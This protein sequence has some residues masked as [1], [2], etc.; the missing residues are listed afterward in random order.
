VVLG[1][2]DSGQGIP[3][4]VRDRIFEPFFTTKD[5][6]KGTGLGLATVL[7]IVEKCGGGVWLHSE[8]NK[9]TTFKI[10]FPSTDDPP[11]VPLDGPSSPILHRGGTILLV[12]DEAQLRAMLTT[13]LEQA[14]YQVLVASGPVEALGLA[15]GHSEVIDLLLTD[16]V[17]PQ[18]TGPALAAELH[19]RDP[20]L[21]VLFM[22]GFTDDAALRS[23]LLDGHIN[24]LPKPL[25]ASVLLRKIGKLLAG[26]GSLVA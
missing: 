20:G 10:Y 18:M 4:D 26:R 12:E 17:M 11:D 1:V 21:V 13:V 14:G 16:V 9:G 2:S 7:G 22:S 23:G 3:A 6:G 5:Q 19:E 24:F 15:Q 25:S 8:L